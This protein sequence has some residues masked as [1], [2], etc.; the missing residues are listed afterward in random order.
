[1]SS[2]VASLL[3]SINIHK[4]IKTRITC[5][6]FETKHNDAYFQVANWTGI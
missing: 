1:M 6:I 5:E 2:I 3:H 4:K